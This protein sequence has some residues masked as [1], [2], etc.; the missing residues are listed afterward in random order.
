MES[1][2][3]SSTMIASYA[4]RLN[5]MNITLLKALAALTLIGVLFF[6]SIGSFFKG[7]TKWL[8]VQLLGAGFLALVTLI[9]I[10]EALQL[11]PWM[12][13]GRPD[14]VGHYLDFSSAI[15]GLT[16][17]PIGFLCAK[18]LKRGR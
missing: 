16:L 15:L 6:W 13:W 10:C 17:F 8:F 3:T 14:S 11:F 9:H 4:T 12:G 18:F 7:K 2:A 5:S 1:S